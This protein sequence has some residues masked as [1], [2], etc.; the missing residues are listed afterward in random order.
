MIHI[1]NFELPKGAEN[2][3]VIDRS[4]NGT[5]CTIESIILG[6]ES[7]K[8]LKAL[9]NARANGKPFSPARYHETISNWP[10]IKEFKE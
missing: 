6:R 1:W 7:K 9:N 2:F 5:L 8:L 4:K 3:Q 10:N